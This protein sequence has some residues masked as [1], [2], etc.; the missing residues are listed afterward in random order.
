MHIAFA[1]VVLALAL[2]HGSRLWGLY[3]GQ[4]LLHRLGRLVIT[5]AAVQVSLGILAFFAIQFRVEGVPRPAW[6]VLLTTA[7]QACGSVLLGC[8]VMGA[9]WSRRLLV[10][11]K[12]AAVPN[13]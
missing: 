9:L 6:D 5:V 2:L 4:P 12:A 1:V 11:T 3:E 10:Q 13:V 8:S 7:H